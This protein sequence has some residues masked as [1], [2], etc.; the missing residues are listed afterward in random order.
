[1][2]DI[3]A[4]SGGIA[5]MQHVLF[6]RR[7]D[8]K[9]A[10]D[11]GDEFPRAGKM[12]STAQNPFLAEGHFIKFHVLLQMQRTQRA[13]AAIAVGSIVK[14]AVIFADHRHGGRGPWGID[15]IA[16]R[17]AKG[18]GNPQRN[19]KRGIG[20]LA[21]D[22]TEHGPTDSTGTGHGFE[23]PAPIRPQLFEPQS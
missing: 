14:R 6:A 18:L 4:V 22:L 11:H 1:M 19:G 7:F 15:Q 5:R 2:G 16:Q 3:G 17:H 8:L 21:L 23:R 13:D 9:L 12:G 10:F 20:L